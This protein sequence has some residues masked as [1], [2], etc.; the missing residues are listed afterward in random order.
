MAEFKDR[1]QY[2][3]AP[4]LMRFLL[5]WKRVEE[6]AFTTDASQAGVFIRTSIAPPQGAQ[7]TLVLPEGRPKDES[8]RI[9]A[10]VVRIVRRGDP[11]NPLGGIAVTF[12][13]IISPRGTQ[14][15]IDLLQTLIGGAD[16]EIPV[17]KGAYV[18]EL[19]AGHVRPYVDDSAATA[20]ADPV[21]LRTWL[22][23]LQL[24]TTS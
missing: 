15:V 17:R 21:M 1:R 22:P 3:R 11:A 13:R 23:T 2:P 24:T 12:E 19:P 20:S 16:F 7:I 5:L 4:K 14:P 10:T 18:V 8:V 9:E 6:K